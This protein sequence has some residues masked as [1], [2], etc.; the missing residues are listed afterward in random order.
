MQVS[1]TLNKDAWYNLVNLGLDYA[2]IGSNI[3]SDIVT[4][5]ELEDE[6]DVLLES[7]GPDELAEF[8]GIDSEFLIAVNVHT[9]E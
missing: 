1:F 5:I 8:F 7:L 9:P 2:K 6:D 3:D 4:V